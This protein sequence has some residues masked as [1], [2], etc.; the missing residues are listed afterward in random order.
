MS[1]NEITIED[2]EGLDVEDFDAA[3]YLT[4]EETIA[5]YLTEVMNNGTYAQLGAAVGTV[6]RARGMAEIARSSGLSREALYKALRPNSQPRFETISKVCRALG[7]RLV[8][9]PIS[10]S[11]KVDNI[12][13]L[14]VVRTGMVDV[15]YEAKV[16]KASSPMAVVVL[17]G[18]VLMHGK[19]AGVPKVFG[20]GMPP[21]LASVPVTYGADT[22]FA[23]SC[24]AH[25]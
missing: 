2:L 18:D 8:A 20:A 24:P 22:P 6:A 19:I 10:E 3:D 11:A 9:E 14:D 13:A 5:A 23:W 21:S 25:P 4:S 1:G 17:A 15:T 16:K 7:V 12:V